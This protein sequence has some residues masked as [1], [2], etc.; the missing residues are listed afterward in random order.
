MINVSDDKTDNGYLHHSLAYFNTTDFQVI[1]M[2]YEFSTKLKS[3]L[4]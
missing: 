2:V 3:Y 4:I 1:Y